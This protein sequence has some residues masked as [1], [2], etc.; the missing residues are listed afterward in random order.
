MKTMRRRS[1]IRASLGLTATFGMLTRPHIANTAANT[2]IVWRDQ[3]FVPE[4][5]IAFRATVADYERASGNA[6]NSAKPDTITDSA[7]T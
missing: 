4:E 1:V 6:C 3:G 2:T 5:D 7:T